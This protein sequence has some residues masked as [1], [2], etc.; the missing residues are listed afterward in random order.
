ML[1][2]WLFI[3]KPVG[4]SSTKVVS[5]V[6]RHLGC[7]KVGHG[8]T[9]DPLASGILPLALGE[10]TKTVSYVMDTTKE[11]HFTLWWGEQRTTDDE[12]GEVIETSPIRP[13]LEEIQSALK[14]FTGD[15]LQIPPQY[16]A[17]KVQGERA[18]NLARCNRPPILA[19]RP[20]KIETLSLLSADTPDS[21]SFHLKC[22]KGVYV[23]SLARDL[24]RFLGTYGYAASIRRTFVGKFG[25][26]AALSFD[27]LA[28]LTPDR[29]YKKWLH[30]I[31][32]VLDDIPAIPIPASLE[33][34]LVKG[35]AVAIE[36]NSGLGLQAQ[37]T[38]LCKDE[39]GIPLAIARLEA[40]SVHPRRVFNIKSLTI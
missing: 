4:I 38:V 36:V 39:A 26:K 27:A 5:Q 3:D 33:G 12:E 16:S 17:I 1:H 30:L 18:Y 25:E 40:G 35:Q 29:L 7:K 2:G 31:T 10:A 23:R 28:N 32:D 8:G 20:V 21:A 24:A 11:Y 13:S 34:R 14:H 15:I 22:H 9:L 6:K 37:G 19:P